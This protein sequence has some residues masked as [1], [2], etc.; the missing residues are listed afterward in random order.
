MRTPSTAFVTISGRET[1][2]SNPSRRIND[3]VR[4]AG[5]RRE[6]AAT[7]IQALQ[8]RPETTAHN[9]RAFLGNRNSQIY[10]VL[11]TIRGRG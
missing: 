2:I 9:R 3:D 8:R 1:C 11:F 7:F 5:A 6:I 10:V 4:D